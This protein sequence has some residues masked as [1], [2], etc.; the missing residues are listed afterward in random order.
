MEQ[1]V[2]EKKQRID[3]V[4]IYR[5]IGVILMI[6]GHIGFG[7]LFN[8]FIHAFHM[9]MFFLIS[10]FLFNAEKN[11]D[12]SIVEF[13]KKK[14][15]ALIIPYF[16]FA[17]L[18]IP[19]WIALDGFSWKPL[20]NVLFFS[21]KELPI[22]DALWFLV[23]LF[24]VDVIYFFLNRFC[25]KQAVLHVI[26]AVLAVVGCLI[27]TLFSF[28]LPLALGPAL[29]GLG[30]FHIGQLTKKYK[31]KKFMAKAINM[32]WY[33]WI[34][35]VGV[36]CVLIFLN[37][38]INM[39]SEKYAIIP[40]FFIVAVLSSYILLTFSNFI[41]RFFQK[42]FFYKWLLFIGRNSIVYV[43]LNQIVIIG[44]RYLASYIPVPNT[45]V[46][47]LALIGI[48][49]VTLTILW[50]CAALFE[51]TKLRVLIGKF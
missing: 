51:K 37:G 14:A 2:V 11:K 38:Y 45:I 6:M 4:D 35:C 24:W 48:L 17:V 25:K 23:A 39:R 18:H 5:A 42:A 47:L 19:A 12:C 44:I 40:L 36:A 15:K 30:L 7:D 41:C 3:F 50:L 43:C 49:I 1:N 13:I 16:V 20:L 21:T 10:G 31:E 29:V 26:I 33:I 22:A 8:H 9:P 28:V 32:P 27:N 46:L 34:V